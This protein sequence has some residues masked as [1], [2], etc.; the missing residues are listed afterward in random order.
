MSFDIPSVE[1]I[2]YWYDRGDVGAMY[3]ACQTMAGELRSRQK[4]QDENELFVA[5]LITLL[6]LDREKIERSGEPLGNVIV[7]T[8]TMLLEDHDRA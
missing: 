4:T 3:T 1:D 6:G 8:I 5:N 2:D 7:S